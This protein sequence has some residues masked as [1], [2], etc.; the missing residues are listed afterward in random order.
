MKQIAENILSWCDTPDEI[1]IQQAKN[2]AKIPYLVGNVCIM[3]N[4]SPDCGASIGTVV[5]LEDAVCPNMVGKDIGCGIS[6]IQTSLT[7]INSEQ[8][9]Q[10]ISVIREK[11]PVG[12]ENQASDQNNPVF[13]QDGWQKL[14]ICSKHYHAAKRQIGTLGEN[15]HFIEIQRGDDG[16]IW[17]MIHSGSRNLGKQI[18]EY[19]NEKAEK[20]CKIWKHDEFVK[21]KLAFLPKGT[22]EFHEYLAEMRLCM[23]FSDASREL[24]V[25]R[26]KEAIETIFQDVTYEDNISIQHNYIAMENH[27]GKNVWVHRKGATL[28]RKDTFGIIPGSQG[29]HSYI[30]IAKGNQQSLY[31]CSNGAGRKISEESAKTELSIEQ[32]Q[33]LM[34]QIG[35]L[36]TIENIN[37]LTTAPSAY[38]DIDI[39]MQEQQDLIDIMIKLQPLAIIKA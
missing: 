17:F 25:Q 39:V 12:F 10:V 37:D 34:D 3:P 38:K 20:L 4:V 22:S 5:A 30:V 36:H 23:Q 14:T 28:A 11:I 33:E 6:A 1:V 16:H 27:F 15:G 24:I 31:S 2:V 7:D 9:K 19:Y 13:E 32:E 26:V 35:V 29:T 18:A 8:L 21:N